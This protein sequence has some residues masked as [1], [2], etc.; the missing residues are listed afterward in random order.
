[1]T[2]SGFWSLNTFAVRSSVMTIGS[3]PQS[4]VITPPRATA[5]TNAFEVQL[6]GV[7]SPIT[8][9]GLE[10]S[11]SWASAGALQ[12]PSPLPMGG[13]SFGLVRGSA[14]AASPQPKRLAAR[15]TRQQYAMN[16]DILGSPI[17]T[18]ATPASPP[19]SGGWRLWHGSAKTR[20]L[21]KA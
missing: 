6:P 21:A 18:L 12:L 7:P 1:M 9:S 19:K 20:A 15:Q 4:N 10:T 17:L 5:S 14:G 3:G 13:P 8:V 16:R 11:S 2:M